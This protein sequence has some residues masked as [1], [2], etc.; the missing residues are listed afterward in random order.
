M[1]RGLDLERMVTEE[2][3]LSEAIRLVPRMLI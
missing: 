2:S 3:W 1:I